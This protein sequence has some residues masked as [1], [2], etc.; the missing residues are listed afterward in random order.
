MEKKIKK[1]SACKK[2]KLVRWFYNKNSYCKVCHK[3]YNKRWSSKNVREG[4]IPLLT[5]TDKRLY[6]ARKKRYEDRE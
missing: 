6:D 1:C 3:E 2:E 4:I 5:D